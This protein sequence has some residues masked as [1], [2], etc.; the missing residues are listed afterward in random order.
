MQDVELVSL[1]YIPFSVNI[2]M[3]KFKK[4][5][6]VERYLLLNLKQVRAKA[7]GNHNNTKM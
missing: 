7:K 5:A 4:R 1:A 6:K 3:V 2:I